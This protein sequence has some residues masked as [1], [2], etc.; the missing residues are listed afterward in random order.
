MHVEAEL[1]A[2][3][4]AIWDP[5][6]GRGVQ[7]VA[8]VDRGSGVRSLFFP[9]TTLTPLSQRRCH[10]CPARSSLETRLGLLFDVKPTQVT[11]TKVTMEI[12]FEILL[13]CIFETPA[14]HTQS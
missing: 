6:V 5:P 2:G 3:F 10:V 12:I 14:E 1:L 8:T 7:I 4:R 13:N 11:R 9:S